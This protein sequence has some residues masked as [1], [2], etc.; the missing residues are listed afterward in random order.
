VLQLAAW[1]GDLGLDSGVPQSVYDLPV[2]SLHH[3]DNAQLAPGESWTLPDGTKISFTGVDQWATF[4][5]AHDPGKRIVLV[6]AIF[7]V[8]GLLC[9]LRVRRRRLWLR[10]TPVVGGDS[11]GRTVS[12]GARIT[13]VEAAGLPRTD[14][15]GFR[16]EFQRL[17]QHIRDQQRMKD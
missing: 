12:L 4:Q 16:Q 1:R 11:D 3:I 10:A 14:P 7:I 8:A 15:D 6:A 2:G 9:S 5:I 13:T 17:V